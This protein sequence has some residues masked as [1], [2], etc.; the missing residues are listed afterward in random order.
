[1][2]NK[3]TLLCLVGADYFHSHSTRFEKKKK[4]RL[5]CPGHSNKTSQAFKGTMS[6][7]IFNMVS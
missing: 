3:S 6:L 7:N 5:N 4:V 2:V 1:M